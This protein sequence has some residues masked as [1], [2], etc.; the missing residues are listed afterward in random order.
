MLKVILKLLIVNI[1]NEDAKT[2]A[3]GYICIFCHYLGPYLFSIQ[4]LT[5]AGQRLSLYYSDFWNKFHRPLFVALN[6]QQVLIQLK[7]YYLQLHYITLKFSLGIYSRIL[8]M[9][10]STPLDVLS[11]VCIWSS[12][13]NKIATTFTVIIAGKL[14]CFW[15]G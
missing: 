13:Q 7:A 9:F 1:L 10:R 3:F 2:F 6:L 8:H 11:P 4:N 15:L 12:M 5:P 14:C